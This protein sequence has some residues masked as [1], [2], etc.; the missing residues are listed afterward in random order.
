MKEVIIYAKDQASEP[1]KKVQ[2]TA[3]EVTKQG[4]KNVEKQIDA[5]DKL[6]K[7]IANVRKKYAE[8]A[9][10]NKEKDKDYQKDENLQKKV[11]EKTKLDRQR[12]DK[13]KLKDKEKTAKEEQKILED[14]AKKE[15]ILARKV[16][17]EKQNDREKFE[18][19]LKRAGRRVVGVGE[20]GINQSIMGIGTSLS[21]GDP[22]SAIGNAGGAIGSSAA[23]LIPYIG[24]IVGTAVSAVTQVF[25]SAIHAAKAK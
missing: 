1:I 22:F 3:D 11:L 10:E 17:L 12:Y 18:K 7:A 16:E 20:T 25:T 2:Q 14:N 13:E 8:S 9:N 5:E 4:I 15:V 19:T 24:G 23:G 21:S 6:I